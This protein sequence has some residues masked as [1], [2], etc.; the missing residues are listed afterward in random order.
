M[1]QK[2][3]AAGAVNLAQGFPDFDGPDEIKLAAIDAIRG[4]FN[5]YAPAPG[6]PALRE[7]IAAFQQETKNQTWSADT[8]VT[9]FTGATEAI[10]CTMQALLDQGDE[11]IAFE[12]FYDSYPAS[13]HAAGARLVGVPLNA[14]DWSFSPAILAEKITSRTRAI[15]VN[16]PHN[17]TGKVFTRAE[18]EAI[19][20]LAKKH[21]LLVI[22]DEVYEQLYFTGAE[23]V[24]MASLPGMAERTVTISSTSKTF[25]MTGWKVG[26]TFAKPEITRLL[27]NVHQFTVFCT[28]TPLQ[29]GMITAFDLPR[30]YY[31]ELRADYQS[32]RDLLVSILKDN[33]FRCNAPDGSYFILA[34]YSGISQKPDLEFAAWLTEEIKVAT[35][36]TSVFYTDPAAVA[37]KQHYVRFAFC[38]G[39][40]TLRQAAERLSRLRG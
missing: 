31:D 2:A 17:P 6:L 38:K 35:I 30:S 26:Y 16:T 23:H 37:A 28:A 13:A 40:A 20:A 12:P 36:P 29:A 25:S 27:R 22:T 9:V 21:D 1:T 8:E 10:F 39:E 14:P 32:K 19:A 24:C 5:Q 3:N 18:L 11:I 33:G 7:K 15:I 4:S 34:D